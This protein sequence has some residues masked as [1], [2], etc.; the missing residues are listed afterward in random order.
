MIKILFIC[1]EDTCRGPMAEGI[2]REML[3]QNNDDKI[4]CQSAGLSDVQEDNISENAVRACMEIGIDI[5]S[6]KARKFA[7]DEIPRWDIYF[8]MSK[9]HGYILEQAGVPKD[10]IYVSG[11]IDDPYGLELDN[12]RAARDKLKD[13]IGRFYNALLMRIN[14]VY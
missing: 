5:S 7:S 14:D 4:M 10:K 3:K 2:F 9:T 13:E 1:P 8:T 6:H 12:F 11:Y